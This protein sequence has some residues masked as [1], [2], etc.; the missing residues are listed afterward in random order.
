MN[1]VWLGICY[2]DLWPLSRHNRSYPCLAFRG[3]SQAGTVGALETVHTPYWSWRS[4]IGADYLEWH[5]EALGAHVTRWLLAN[6][7]K[8][9]LFCGLLFRVPRKSLLQGHRV[10]KNR[11]WLAGRPCRGVAIP[12]D[13][14]SRRIQVS[15]RYKMTSARLCDISYKLR[16]VVEKR[17]YFLT[18]RCLFSVS[19]PH[20]NFDRS[21]P[22]GVERWGTKLGFWR[23]SKLR[24]SCCLVRE[25][26]FC[27][28]EIDSGGLQSFKTGKAENFGSSFTHSHW[29]LDNYRKTSFY[30][31]RPASDPGKVTGACADSREIGANSNSTYVEALW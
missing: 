7:L 29:A 15:S 8:D 25:N 11:P 5:A 19:G 9:R 21:F 14:F 18:V 22:P 23:H 24:E 10:E 2:S 16:G 17:T 6:N 3:L 13:L 1:G 20:P 4:I 12:T 30:S 28:L 26:R 31:S 27:P